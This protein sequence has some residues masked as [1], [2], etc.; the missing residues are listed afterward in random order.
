MWSLGS[1]IGS[2]RLVSRLASDEVACSYLAERTGPL[3]FER[4]VEISALH[5]QLSGS[6][7]FA[8][9]FV[10]TARAFA[11]S[12]LVR[13][14]PVEDV[15]IES[16]RLYRVSAAHA[17][18]CVEQWMQRLKASGVS[19]STGARCFI[20]LEVLT[21]C[22]EVRAAAARKES[23]F[24]LPFPTKGRPHWPGWPRPPQLSDPVAFS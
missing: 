7:L 11:L 13:V 17:G 5:T 4:S 15:G 20:A 18:L 6:A 19:L 14:V 21:A 22:L 8:G 10:R 2:Y 3:G 1:Q 12:P 23:H 24:D 9:S 16:G